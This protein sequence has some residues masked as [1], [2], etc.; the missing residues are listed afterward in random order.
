MS[1]DIIE[2]I[3]KKH[4]YSKQKRRALSMLVTDKEICKINRKRKRECSAYEPTIEESKEYKS[5]ILKPPNYDSVNKN[6]K[7]WNDNEQI[8]FGQALENIEK[9]ENNKDDDIMIIDKPKYNI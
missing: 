2:Q 8:E 7:I 1:V 9:Q 6:R 3:N 5:K 4:F